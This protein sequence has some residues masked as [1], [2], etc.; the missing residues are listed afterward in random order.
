MKDMIRHAAR[1]GKSPQEFRAEEDKL[2]KEAR[3]SKTLRHGPTAKEFQ[4]YIAFMDAKR[5]TANLWK[6]V[7]NLSLG[8][9]M[10]GATPKPIQTNKALLPINQAQVVDDLMHIHG[11]QVSWSWNWK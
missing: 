9:W 6:R 11:H 10:P 1:Q 5:R 4:T 2:D 3:Y 8:W 7:Y